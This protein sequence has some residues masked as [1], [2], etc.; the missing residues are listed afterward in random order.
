L[1]EKIGNFGGT[2]PKKANQV[3]MM[4]EWKVEQK[5][6]RGEQAKSTILV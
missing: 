3:R 2:L 6:E 5:M 1:R 4:V